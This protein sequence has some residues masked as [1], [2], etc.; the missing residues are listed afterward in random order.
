VSAA[1]ER[2]DDRPGSRRQGPDLRRPGCRDRGAGRRLLPA[3]RQGPRRSDRGRFAASQRTDR[4]HPDL[5]QLGAGEGPRTIEVGKGVQRGHKAPTSNGIVLALS[6][7]AQFMIVL[8]SYEV[9]MRKLAQTTF[10]TQDGVIGDGPSWTAPHASPEYRAPRSWC[11]W[12]RSV[13][14]DRPASSSARTARCP[15]S[16]QVGRPTTWPAQPGYPTNGNRR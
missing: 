5:A 14:T 3:R 2:R 6:C 7:A 15:G 10:V 1:E 4:N 16:G 11:A 8:D 13:R 12:P 9:A